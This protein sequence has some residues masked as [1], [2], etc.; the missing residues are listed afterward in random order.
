MRGCLIMIVRQPLVYF[1]SIE[2]ESA[3]FEAEVETLYGVG[4]GA[5]GDEVDAAF[6]VLAEGVEGDAAG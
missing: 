1:S 3:G 5:Y 2:Q 6:S 4:Q